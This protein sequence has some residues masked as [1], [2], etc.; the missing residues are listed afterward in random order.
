M[1]FLNGYKGESDN[2]KRQAEIWHHRMDST[3]EALSKKTNVPDSL[4]NAMLA[5]HQNAKRAWFNL[6]RGKD[7][8]K[9]KGPSADFDDGFTAEDVALCKKEAAAADKVN[10][11][12]SETLP[13]ETITTE[14]RNN[15]A[16]INEGTYVLITGDP[17]M[18]TL[19]VKARSN[20][21][22]SNTEVSFRLKIE[23]RRDNRQDE[24]FFPANGAKRIKA[25]K[26][27][28]ID[29][30]GNI[31]GGK[32]TLYCDYGTKKD[33]VIF[34]IRGT[35]PTEQAVRDHI[36]SQGYGIWFFTRL[37]RQESNFRQFNSGR[38]H[39]E[40]NN[41][42]GCPN[43]GMPHGWGLMQLDLL[44][45]GQRPTAQELWNWKANIDRG[46]LFLNGE[47]RRMVNTHFSRKL[48][49]IQQWNRRNQK[50]SVEAHAD[51][52]EGLITYSH[53]NSNYF[54]HDFGR[55]QQGTNKSFI[56]ATWIK[57]YNGSSRPGGRGGYYYD[58]ERTDQ[59]CAPYWIIYNLNNNNHNYV[60][61]VSNRAE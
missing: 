9:R 53:A 36:A 23:Y 37:I 61:A 22:N 47:K 41:G 12:V 19:S 7:G 13:A 5:A 42:R 39:T 40:R 46:Y 44:D 21:A 26:N 60:E 51:Q 49:I 3:V 35:N 1:D 32:A 27:W 8:Q 14:L 28:D 31:R 15:G 38:R 17:T 48:A 30:G 57:N 11:F 4:M 43:W 52:T 29:F 6:E 20:M 54:T 59:Q 18:P 58:I 10:E 56:D 25:N 50:D 45:G 2:D 33:T 16:L 34:H 55:T 24:N